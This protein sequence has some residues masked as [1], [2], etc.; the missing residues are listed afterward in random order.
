MANNVNIP[1]EL[2]V[3]F[4]RLMGQVP[5]KIRD[6]SHTQKVIQLFLKLGGEKLAGQYIE[7]VKL[8]VREEE[9]Q[10]IAET[11]DPEGSDTDDEFS[12]FD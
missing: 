9:R 1:D 6:D 7:I 3:A 2:I 5:E 12:D 4:K 8:N 11:E 10:N